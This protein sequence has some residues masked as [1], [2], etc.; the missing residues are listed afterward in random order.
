MGQVVVF[1]EAGESYYGKNATVAN[2]RKQVRNMRVHTEG[3][4]SS[5]LHFEENVGGKSEQCDFIQMRI[6]TYSCLKRVQL[7]TQSKPK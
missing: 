3:M 4:S 1:H 7:L 5:N 6:I 2:Y